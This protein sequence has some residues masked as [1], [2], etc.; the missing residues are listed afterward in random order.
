MSTKA[1][2]LPKYKPPQGGMP[3]FISADPNAIESQ[4]VSM[5]QQAYG[6]SD[7]DFRQR[8]PELYNSQQTF[9]NNLNTQMSGGIA[10]QM[11]N[12]WL[13]GGLNQAVG[14]TG[15]WSLGTGTT[16]MANIARNL[17]LDQM[18]YQNQI[19]NQ[20]QMA[21]DTFRPRTFGLSGGDTAQIALANIAGQ[22]NWNQANYAYKVQE[23]QYAAGQGAQQAALNAN[24]AN[25]NTATG[26]GAATTGA[27][28][29]VLAVAA[30]C[31]VAREAYGAD[32]RRWQRFRVWMLHFAPCFA[33]KQYIRHGRR[34]AGW[35][36]AHAW[37]KPAVRVLMDF[38]A[39]DV[40]LF[41][42]CST[43]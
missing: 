7:A 27:S 17:G 43:L 35:L 29:A 4:A 13:R 28:L 18:Q 19:L 33:R 37:L 21:N 39:R 3:P 23:S 20:F 1:P 12:A 16:G 5:D 42:L 32:N 22:N 8:Y 40:C 6:M 2:Q 14:A 9:L 41:P 26:V 38:L 36:R 34:A 15:N 31:W 30:F 24:A 11:E 10:P 25:A